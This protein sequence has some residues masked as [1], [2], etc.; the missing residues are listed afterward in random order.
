MEADKA[1]F[2]CSLGWLAKFG[3]VSSSPRFEAATS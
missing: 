1:G 2:D 3:S